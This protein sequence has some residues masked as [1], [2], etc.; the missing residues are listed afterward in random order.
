MLG[1]EFDEDDDAAPVQQD[2]DSDFNVDD[3]ESDSDGAKKVMTLSS[4][5]FLYRSNIYCLVLLLFF[6]FLNE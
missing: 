2:D 3:V 6:F 1:E 5:Q 4:I